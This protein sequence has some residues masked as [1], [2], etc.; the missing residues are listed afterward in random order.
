[1]LS[2]HLCLPE[3]L[4]QTTSAIAADLDDETWP[5]RFKALIGLL[6]AGLRERP[7]LDNARV[8]Q[9]W[10]GIVSTVLE[11]L[12]PDPTKIE[13]LMLMSISYDDVWRA[14]AREG[15][16]GSPQLAEIFLRANPRWL[17]IAEMLADA[18][19]RY[20]LERVIGWPS[21]VSRG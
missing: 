17:K 9:Q 13:C 6:E 14:Q 21:E 1:V 8:F 15:L 5:V 19:R 11:L 4:R 18:H 12:T 2:F 16:E 20:P 7:G 3:D 10:A